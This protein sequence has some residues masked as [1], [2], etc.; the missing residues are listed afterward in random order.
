MFLV[1]QLESHLLPQHSLFSQPNGCL[2]VSTF[3]KADGFDSKRIF[4]PLSTLFFLATFFFEKTQSKTNLRA[5]FFYLRV[6][7][8][9]TTKKNQ[10][11]S[12]KNKNNVN[13]KKK[14]FRVGLKRQ[15]KKESFNGISFNG[16]N[17]VSFFDA[18]A[19]LAAELVKTEVK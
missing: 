8:G 4:F 2:G 12:T 9:R 5:V 18:A 3:N 6:R 16:T 17:V 14:D 10:T 13:A 19:E 1:H 7:L 11:N 15:S